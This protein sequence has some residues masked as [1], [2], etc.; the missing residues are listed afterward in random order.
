[1]QVKVGMKVKVGDGNIKQ[2]RGT[3]N[4]LVSSSLS[5]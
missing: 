4:Q 3:H 2:E 1:M 5:L